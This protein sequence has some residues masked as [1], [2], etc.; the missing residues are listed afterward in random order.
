MV[1][2]YL[3]WRLGLDHNTFACTVPASYNAITINWEEE[4]CKY[5]PLLM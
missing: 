3:M 1:V 4:D 5:I 2:A